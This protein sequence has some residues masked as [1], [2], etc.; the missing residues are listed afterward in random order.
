M[1]ASNL[2]VVIAPNVL[3]NQK[4]DQSKLLEEIKDSNYVFEL[5]M[6]NHDYVFQNIK[7][8][9]FPLSDSQ[10]NNNSDNNNNNNANNNN[11]N[12]ATPSSSPEKT[13]EPVEKLK[14]RKSEKRMKSR[15]HGSVGRQ[16]IIPLFLISLFSLSFIIYFFS[17]ITYNFESNQFKV[18][19]RTKA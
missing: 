18:P 7:K 12:K 3:R 10:E 16:G 8:Q 9:P 5:M 13:E 4:Q 17:Q 2:A 1:T 14:R 6:E 11:I 15:T 19:L